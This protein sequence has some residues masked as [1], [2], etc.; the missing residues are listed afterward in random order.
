MLKDRLERIIE[1]KEKLMDD[2]EREI[3]EIVEKEGKELE[4]V[5]GEKG[6]EA[7]KN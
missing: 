7:S 2:K 4:E 5:I 1:I 6:Q 3:E